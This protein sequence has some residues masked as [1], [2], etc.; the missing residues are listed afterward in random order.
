MK[1]EIQIPDGKAVKLL[2]GVCA[3]TGWTEA[4]GVSQ[5]QW[6]KDILVRN[7]R[8]TAK[9][10]LVRQQVTEIGGNVDGVSIT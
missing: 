2:E 4:S 1:I 10:G 5:E 3:A 9:R 7:L 8:E 6:T